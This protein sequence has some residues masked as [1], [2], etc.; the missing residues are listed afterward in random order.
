MIYIRYIPSSP[1]R[2]LIDPFKEPF[3]DIFLNSRIL[4]SPEPLVGGFF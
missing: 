2:T 4:E 3:K 1:Y